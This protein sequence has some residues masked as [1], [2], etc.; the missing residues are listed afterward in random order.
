MSSDA[1]GQQTIRER[2]YFKWVN[3]GS[4]ETDGLRF[5]LDAESEELNS[6]QPNRQSSSQNSSR[7]SQTPG[8]ITASGR[9]SVP[10]KE[11]LIGTRG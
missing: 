4:P 6:G 5:W 10:D 7:P 9:N 2:A 3:A 1:S 11:E 8:G